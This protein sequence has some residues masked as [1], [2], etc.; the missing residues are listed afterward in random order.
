MEPE[1]K[2][3]FS[4]I[5]A[6]VNMASV[7]QS[8]VSPVTSGER[9]LLFRVQK[10]ETAQQQYMVDVVD[11]NNQFEKIV[12]IDCGNGKFKDMPGNG[13]LRIC[14]SVTNI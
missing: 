1:Y 4:G 10:G 5:S 14:L 11:V 6:T 8:P 3:T 9:K 12:N 13:L 7:C 2:K